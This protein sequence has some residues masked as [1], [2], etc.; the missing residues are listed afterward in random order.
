MIKILKYCDDV[1]DCNYAIHPLHCKTHESCCKL[2]RSLRSFPD[3]IQDKIL[4]KEDVDFSYVIFITNNSELG[5]CDISYEIEIHKQTLKFEISRIIDIL[6]GTD[7]PSN[8]IYFKDKCLGSFSGDDMPRIPIS[9]LLHNICISCGTEK[10]VGNDVY[11]L[12]EEKKQLTVKGRV[13]NPKYRNYEEIAHKCAQSLK[14][15][16]IKFSKGELVKVSK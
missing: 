4:N 10:L 11:V 1:C 2:R 3:N 6:L 13:F 7:S 5:Y 14:R 9:Q 15:C 12:S 16:G 8:V